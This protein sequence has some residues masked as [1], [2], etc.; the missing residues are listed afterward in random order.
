MGGSALPVGLGLL[1]DDKPTKINGRPSM[2]ETIAAGGCLLLGYVAHDLIV[3]LRVKVELEV[4]N[5][6]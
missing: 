1:A 2:N 5:R 3:R 4:S 6:R